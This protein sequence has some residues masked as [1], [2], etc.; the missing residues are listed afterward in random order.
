MLQEKDSR[1]ERTR[2]AAAGPYHLRRRNPGAQAGRCRRRAPAGRLRQYRCAE[3]FDLPVGRRHPAR[4]GDSRDLQDHR[5]RVRC[6]GTRHP[7]PAPLRRAGIAG[8]AGGGRV[9]RLRGLG[10]GLGRRRICGDGLVSR[11]LRGALLALTVLPGAAAAQIDPADLLPV[12]EAF[13]LR[14]TVVED[15]QAVRLVWAVADG[16]YM[17]RHAFGAEAAVDGLQLAA[18][19]P[20]PGDRYTDEFFGEVEVYRGRAVVRVPVEAWPGTVRPGNDVALNVKFQGCADLGVCYPPHR[21]R[22]TVARPDRSAA[23]ATGPLMDPAGDPAPSREAGLDALLRDFDSTGTQLTG[24]GE[25]LPPE[26]A[27]RV[28]TIAIG[29]DEL[30]ARFTVHPEY[31]LYRD[32]IAFA[33][34]APDVAL[35]APAFPPA[36]A[37]TD[38]FF[39]DTFVYFNEV[40]IPV[41]LE[42]PPGPARSIELDVAYQGCQTDGICYPPMTR[43]IEVDLPA[44]ASGGVPVTP[45][46]GPGPTAAPPATEQGRLAGALAEQPVLAL[47]LFFVA[48][49]LLAFT[50]CVFPMVP[51]LSGLIAGDA[52][53]MSTGRAFRLSVVYV[54]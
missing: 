27:F 13:A 49:V 52:E 33:T 38:E 11:W 41:P 45:V 37:I 31:Y 12:E 5:Q 44:A 28:E 18:I 14:A 23:P 40:E 22:V 48:G 21:Q 36:E 51:I 2:H 6:A 17:Y 50:P 20:E 1:N 4:R 35:G 46:D 8:G 25:P 24:R 9:G 3:R 34:A 30:L 39:G 53:R 19:E 15:G 43:T 29:P 42:R 32:T 54:L 47:L 10:A 7:A 16:Y 26:Q